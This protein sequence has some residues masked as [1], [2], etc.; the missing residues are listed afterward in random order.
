VNR[1]EIEVAMNAIGTETYRCNQPCS[2]ICYECG[3]NTCD[4]HTE[5][6]ELCHEF[7]CTGC[8]YIHAQEPHPKPTLTVIPITIRKRFA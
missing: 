7:L 6:C 3:T 8:A 4:L 2:L 5:E 1:C